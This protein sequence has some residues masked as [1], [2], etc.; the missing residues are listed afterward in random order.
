MGALPV[1]AA[2]LLVN[3]FTIF[4]LVNAEVGAS[5]RVPGETPDASPI[6]AITK[7]PLVSIKSLHSVVQDTVLLEYT[8]GVL[9]RLALPKLYSSCLIGRCLNALKSSLLKNGK[10]ACHSLFSEW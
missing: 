6:K 4:F 8:N 9:V 3:V 7:G 10:D 1:V 2:L 5:V